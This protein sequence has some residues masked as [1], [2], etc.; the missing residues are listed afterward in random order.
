MP[1][2]SGQWTA[3]FEATP[4]EAMGMLVAPPT[5]RFDLSDAQRPDQSLGR[6]SGR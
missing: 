4:D 3:W 2:E 1:L 5:E 6:Q